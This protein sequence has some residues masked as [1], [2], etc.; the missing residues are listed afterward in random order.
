VRRLLLCIL[1]T[2]GLLASSAGPASAS[3]PA[4]T[5]SVAQFEIAFL[6]GMIPHHMMA[7]HEGSMAPVC[8]ERAI[9]PELRQ[10]CQNIIRDQRR[11]IHIMQG[12]L[13]DWYGIEA[14]MDHSGGHGM[15]P[16]DM[17][18]ML[19]ALPMLEGEAFEI[20]FLQEMSIHHRSAVREAR[21]CLRTAEHQELLDL[22]Q[23]IVTSQRAEIAQMQAWWCSWYGGCRAGARRGDGVL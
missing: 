9:H 22:C 16:R 11:E 2:V 1:A 10:L 3:A 7:A 8:V 17:A 21:T 6:K 13:R 15:G 18:V 5:P 20:L 12:W 4:S 23:S 19:E 14:G